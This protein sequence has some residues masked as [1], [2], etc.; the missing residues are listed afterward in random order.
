MYKKF[1]M[2]IA[3]MAALTLVSCS[4]DDLDSFSDN[5]SKNEAISFDGYLGRSAVAVNGSRG[6][7]ETAN[8][9]QT[10]GFGVFS[11]YSGTSFPDFDNQKVTYSNKKWT[12]SPLK[13][14]PTEGQIKFY[15]YAPYKE[16]QTLKGNTNTFDFTVADNAAGQEDLLWAN[17]TGETTA[18]SASAKE[19]VK[20]HFYHALSRLGYTV[21]LS[22]NYSS[23]NVT[24]ILKNITL[25]G[26]TDG[27]TP[28]FYKTGTINL[29]KT[30][31]ETG[32]WSNYTGGK[33]KFNWY[34]GEYNIPE[35]KAG[36]EP[37]PS[38]PDKDNNGTIEKDKDYLFVIPQN[39]PEKIEDPEHSGQQIDNPD[40]LYVIVEYTI[41]YGGGVKVDNKV[42]K[43]LTQEFKQGKAY[44]LNLTIGLPIEFDV[45]LTE[46][47]GVEG[48]GTDNDI[49]I[50]SNDNP[51]DRK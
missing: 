4:S 28:A 29:A 8:T 6:S 43:R 2:G 51:W 41:D 37:S 40:K 5:S 26:S 16:G 47:V 12:Y 18:N 34:S 25:A 35:P 9:L 15:A 38:H 46:G 45:D 3:A 17:A 49:N 33:L 11:K 31:N 36:T 19:K 32:V 13:F 30:N 1:F 22:G 44:M 20:I 21:K 27:N 42:Y 23:N 39:F 50:G 14:W 7:V 48:W 24:F 10:N